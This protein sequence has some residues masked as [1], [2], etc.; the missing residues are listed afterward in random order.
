[1]FRMFRVLLDA[2]KAERRAHARS[3]NAKS[4]TPQKYTVVLRWGS[5]RYEEYNQ[6]TPEIHIVCADTPWAAIMRAQLKAAK[7]NAHRVSEFVDKEGPELLAV[8][9]QYLTHLVV[10]DGS[11]TRKEPGNRF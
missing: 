7:E 11:C 3:K 1:M 10:F 5:K 2:W 6:G 4:A 9:Q 8:A